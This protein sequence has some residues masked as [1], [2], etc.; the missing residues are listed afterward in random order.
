MGAFVIGGHRSCRRSGTASRWSPTSNAC[1]VSGAISDCAQTPITFSAVALPFRGCY[2]VIPGLR[3]SEQPGSPMTLHRRSWF[4]GSPLKRTH[5]NG[6][7]AKRMRFGRSARVRGLAIAR[8]AVLAG[9]DVTVA[10]NRRHR[11]WRVVA[12]QRGDPRRSLL[13]DR[14]AARVPL[15]A[16]TPTSTTT[17]RR[18][19][20]PSQRRQAVS[21]PPTR[22]S[23]PR[24]R[25]SWRK[26]DQRR[27][28][29]RDDGRQRGARHGGSELSCIGA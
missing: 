23:W 25:R 12:Q 26:R 15:R 29:H 1:T 21:P 2:T 24:S 8:A 18:T 17:V 13:S 28:G 3:G 6:K 19:A 20:W 27:R 16:R 7:A 10:D 4:P 9:H 22:R 11:Q 5:R 14:H